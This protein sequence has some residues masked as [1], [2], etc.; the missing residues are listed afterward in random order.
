MSNLFLETMQRL[1]PSLRAGD[2]DS[3]ER[4]FI[5]Q[6]RSLPRSPFDIAIELC[7]SNDPAHAAAHFDIAWLAPGNLANKDATVVALS[8]NSSL[9][10]FSL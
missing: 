1:T 7:I 5:A 3:C 6:M 10:Q 8:T 9:A 2:F 4:H